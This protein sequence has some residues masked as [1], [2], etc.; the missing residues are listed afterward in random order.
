MVV[1]TCTGEARFATHI[2]GKMNTLIKITSVAAI[3][4]LSISLSGCSNS[5]TNS[6]DASGQAG[7]NAPAAIQDQ[8]KIIEVLL[9]SQQQATKTGLTEKS[10][11]TLYSYDPEVNRS[12]RFY[13]DQQQE[14]IIWQ[15]GKSGS[16]LSQLTQMVLEST[17]SDVSTKANEISFTV[18][19][20][21]NSGQ[22]GPYKMSFE[23][24]DGLVVTMSTGD[25]FSNYKS[26][27]VYKVTD[28]AKEAFAKAI[29]SEEAYPEE[30]YQEPP[31]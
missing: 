31:Q 30:F 7:E 21:R 12:I 3:A 5:S 1:N 18:L 6:S 8:L 2:G 14:P 24:K 22:G 15:E 26:T 11:G 28:E 13:P 20:S 25:E 17:V 23:L 10:S 9:V 27:I 4:A 19:D 29:S 16:T